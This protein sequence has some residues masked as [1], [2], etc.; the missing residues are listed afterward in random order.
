MADLQLHLHGAHEVDCENPR[1]T[2]I[3]GQT[4]ILQLFHKRACD[5]EGTIHSTTY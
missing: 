2:F 4:N 1:E 5:R 3:A